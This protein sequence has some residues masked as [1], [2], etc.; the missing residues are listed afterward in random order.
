LLYIFEDQE[1]LI[2]F[3]DEE[4]VSK[5]QLRA[6][7]A[8]REDLNYLRKLMQSGELFPDIRDG[9]Q[10]EMI[11]THLSTID[12]PI[13]TIHTL[14]ED[15]K[16]LKPLRKAVVKLL[17]PNF[18]GT[19][20]QALEHAF[21]GVNQKEGQCK[22]QVGEASFISRPGNIDDQIWYGIL[23]LWLY[24]MRHFD[25]L[26]G[27]CPKKEEKQD[28]PAP[29][30][31]SPFLWH[32]Y[33][34]LAD[35]VGFATKQIRS[36]KSKNPDIEVAYSALLKARDPDY[37]TYDETLILKHL[38]GMKQMF[39]TATE[40]PYSGSQPTLLVDGPGEAIPRRCGRVFENA[41]KQNRRLLFLSSIYEPTAGKGSGISSFFVRRSVFFAF[42]GRPPKHSPGL[43]VSSGD[44]PLSDPMEIER[45][46]I[47]TELED[48][49]SPVPSTIPPKFR[50]ANPAQRLLQIIGYTEPQF[51]SSAMEI[52]RDQIPTSAVSE[53]SASPSPTSTNSEDA[54]SPAHRSIPP[55]ITEPNPAQRLLQIIGKTQPQVQESQMMIMPAEHPINASTTPTHQTEQFQIIRNTQPQFQGSRMMIMPAPTPIMASTRPTHETEPSSSEIVLR[56]NAIENLNPAEYVVF[57]KLLFYITLLTSSRIANTPRTSIS[58]LEKLSPLCS[59]RRTTK[60]SQ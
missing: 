41:Y 55:K 43:G 39:D 58:I 16:Y 17:K 47:S 11:W 52:E 48:A 35:S 19:V 38:R 22:I 18:K 25:E 40:K 31:P 28:L 20:R 51:Q 27:D 14:F 60:Q 34:V 6:P 10:R 2:E 23:T 29:K 42:F 49:T 5:L 7:G 57:C 59:T 30:E 9:H 32:R 26:V 53:D 24:P 3:A 54:T 37:Y 12:V 4:S 50:E 21:T 36:L 46:Q 13:P 15:I 56:Q 33:G 8:S 45:D 1:D 44:V